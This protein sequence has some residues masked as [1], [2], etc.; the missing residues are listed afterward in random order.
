MDAIDRFLHW[1]QVERGFSGHT[2]E[3]YSRELVRFKSFLEEKSWDKVLAEDIRRYLI[4]LSELGLSPRSVFHNL[5]VIRSFYRFL[6]M[7]KMVEHN[8]SELV[9][10]PKLAKTLPD[11]LSVEEVEKLINACDD[12]TTLGIRDR[13]ILELLYG[14][15]LRVSEL[16]ELKLDQLN[17]SAQYLIA[18]GKGKKERVVP[19]GDMAKKALERY[20]KQS[21]PF[22]DKS[23]TSPYVFVGRS[24]KKLTRQWVFK[25]VKK[26][27]LKAGIRT[28]IS[29]H[30][31]RHSF[32]THL[33]EGGADLRVVQVLLGHSDISAT[34]IY[35]HLDKSRL[36]KEYRDKHPRA[37]LK[38]R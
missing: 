31:L 14:C 26:M 12:K 18:Y 29:P 21:R 32:A 34:Q 16:V 17:L 8:P 35:T 4:S 6:L 20:L 23:G 24:G 38:P 19:I 36:W 22:L 33:L 30:T 27:A 1:L 10:F 15:G 13:A 7:E 28:D 11:V 9:D 3:S 5:A 25:L 37:Q 2:L